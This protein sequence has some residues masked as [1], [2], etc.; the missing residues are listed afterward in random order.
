MTKEAG[1]FKSEYSSYM[2]KMSDTIKNAKLEHAKLTQRVV[3][4]TEYISVRLYKFWN[5]EGEK[6]YRVF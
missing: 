3:L 2:V 4:Y 1:E 5:L 6:E